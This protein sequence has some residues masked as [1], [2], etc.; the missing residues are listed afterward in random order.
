MTGEFNLKKAAL[1]S[2]VT[3]SKSN[4]QDLGCAAADSPS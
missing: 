1:S 3:V 4:S 2:E